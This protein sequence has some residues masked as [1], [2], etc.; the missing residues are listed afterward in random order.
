[1]KAK[2]HCKK[3][4]F[5]KVVPF[6]RLD[7]VCMKVTDKRAKHKKCN[8]DVEIT[9]IWYEYKDETPS[10]KKWKEYEKRFR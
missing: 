9:G 7:Y 4:G 6:Q 5:V 8:G 1:M 2:I 10:E 3:C